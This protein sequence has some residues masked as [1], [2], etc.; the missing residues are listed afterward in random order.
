V[1][2][3]VAVVVVR[4]HFGSRVW[5]PSV[6]AVLSVGAIA[7]AASRPPQRN[8]ATEVACRCA[9]L[10]FTVFAALAPPGVL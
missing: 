2:V 7:A 1:V 6:A 9:T 3:V 5:A 4:S 8:A 10:V